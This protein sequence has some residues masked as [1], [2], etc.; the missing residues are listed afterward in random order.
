MLVMPADHLIS[1]EPLFGATVGQ[2][3]ALAAQG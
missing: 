1:D 2:A 3:A